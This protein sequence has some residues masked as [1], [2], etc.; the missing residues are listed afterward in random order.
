METAQSIEHQSDRPKSRPVKIL[1][2]F[3]PLGD[4]ASD[5]AASENGLKHQESNGDIKMEGQET[6]AMPKRPMTTLRKL[7]GRLEDP[8]TVRDL[9]VSSTFLLS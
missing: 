9:I 1:D 5:V 7:L 2:I 4:K 3:F 6:E 8:V